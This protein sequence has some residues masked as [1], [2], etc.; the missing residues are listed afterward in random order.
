MVLKHTCRESVRYPSLWILTVTSFLGFYRYANT[1]GGVNVGP[2]G[3]VTL[4]HTIDYTDS[5]GHGL[6][7]GAEQMTFRGDN[8]R[9]NV[10]TDPTFAFK[11][12]YR[13][14]EITLEEYVGIVSSQNAFSP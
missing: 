12:Y 11:V 5:A 4:S 13:L 6:L 3:Q 10:G 7:V 14:K 8:T 9:M 2:F 1:I